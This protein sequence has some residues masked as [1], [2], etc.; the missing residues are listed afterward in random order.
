MPIYTFYLRKPDGSA[1]HFEA[2]ELSGDQAA[3]ARARELLERHHSASHVEAFDHDR[4]VLTRSRE[5]VA[6]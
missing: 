6:G 4:R 3:E 2:H 1:P 5:S